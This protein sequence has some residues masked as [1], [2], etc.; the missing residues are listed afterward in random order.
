MD[1]TIPQIKILEK[2]LYKICKAE[3]GQDDTEEKEKHKAN[4]MAFGQTIKM[5]K[6]KTG[7]DNFTLQEIMNPPETIEKYK[8][9]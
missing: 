5:L 6:E 8:K 9:G 4:R 2:Y 1:L 3:A 7:R